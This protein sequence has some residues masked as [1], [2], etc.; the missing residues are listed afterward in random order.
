MVGGQELVVGQAITLRQ[1]RQRV[2]LVNAYLYDYFPANACM[3]F[4]IP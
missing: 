4:S 3:P 2:A 1:A